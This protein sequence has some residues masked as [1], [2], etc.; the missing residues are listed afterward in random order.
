MT[1][2]SPLCCHQVMLTNSNV[3][4]E[5][6]K[7]NDSTAPEVDIDTAFEPVDVWSKQLL[8]SSAADYVLE[9]CMYSLTKAVAADDSESRKLSVDVYLKQTR[10]LARDQFFHRALAFKVRAAQAQA[11]VAQMAT[12]VPYSNR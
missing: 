7:H 9:D 8:E 3:V 12:R 5:W 4:E 1:V 6:L 2:L 11:Q 10:A